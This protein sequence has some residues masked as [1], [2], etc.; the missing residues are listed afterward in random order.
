MLRTYYELDDDRNTV[1]DSGL[2]LVC[3]PH[4]WYKNAN[5]AGVLRLVHGIGIPNHSMSEKFQDRK[6][7]IRE[8]RK[9]DPE[10]GKPE[11]TQQEVADKLGLSRGRIS[12][13]EKQMGFHP[14]QTIQDSEMEDKDEDKDSKSMPE[15]QD[16]EPDEKE[17]DSW[18]C[19]SCGNNTFYDANEYLDRF[20]DHLNR[21][22]I[23]K[24]KNGKRVCAAC[25]TI[26]DD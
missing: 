13:I 26:S 14:L 11:H 25:G 20:I 12:Q 19:N 1:D 16:E 21:N 15:K 10:T 5:P 2:H 23:K 9:I 18:I 8:M 6:R 24:V 17:T 22:Q 7:T 3:M 4:S